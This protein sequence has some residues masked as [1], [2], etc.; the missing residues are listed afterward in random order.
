MSSPRG[1]LHT[2]PPSLASPARPG[3]ALLALALAV[4]GCSSAA[5]LAAGESEPFNG[6]S[7]GGEPQGSAGM[8]PAETGQ[9]GTTTGEDSGPDPSGGTGEA[10]TGGVPPTP[11][12]DE[13]TPADE[14]EKS[15]QDGGVCGPDTW[16]TW[17]LAVRDAGAMVSP[18]QARELAYKQ[19]PPASEVAIRPW[20]F[21]NYYSF[22]YPLAPWNELKAGVQMRAG[23]DDFG[24]MFDVQLAVAGPE[25]AASDR[26]AVHLTFALDNSGS[27][28]GKPTL[29]L[30]RAVKAMAGQL[31]A[32]DTVAV[33]TW[34]DDATVLLPVTAV[35]GPYDG[36]LLAALDEFVA[37]GSAE[38]MT[39]LD[40]GYA[41]AKEAYV[42]TDI[43]RVVVISDGQATATA[44]ELDIIAERAVDMPSLPGIH[45]I[46]VGVGV[47]SMY[48]RDLIDAIGQAGGGP[49]LFIGSEAEADRQLGEKFVSVVGLAALD[50]AVVLTL[51]PGL[52]LV[53][54][55]SNELQP[56]ALERVLLGPNDRVVVHRKLR[57]CGEVDLDSKLRVEMQW[58]DGATGA[59]K[60]AMQEFELGALLSGDDAQLAK[61]EAV[62][63]YAELL[64]ATQSYPGD[65]A[66]W[67]QAMA[68]LEAA[69]AKLP[70]DPELQDIA[71]VLEQL[72]GLQGL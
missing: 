53:S 65:E 4:A 69:M 1:P 72:A 36:Q 37:D 67:A 8:D 49:T 7:T 39:A 30:R 3:A 68:A 11:P 16:L 18:A 26:P 46:G 57:A 35:A 9:A 20:E 14:A 6:G 70:N 71:G 41:L 43:N 13:P 23:Q 64:R 51:P 50:L 24:D 42:P 45:A 28:D 21:L 2:R 63:A 5:D 15:M 60:Q 58:L 56:A 32:G 12:P 31:R 44:E 52:Q 66:A 62:L 48:R 27:M 17:H 55:V 29:L 40:A 10:T 38:L 34:N 59:F 47:G 22:A 25:I 54:D 33:T 19:W 61:G